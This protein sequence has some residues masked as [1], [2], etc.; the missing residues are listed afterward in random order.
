VVI[1]AVVVVV[2][3]VAAEVEEGAE[4]RYQLANPVRAMPE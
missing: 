2:D 1:G 4:K 3:D